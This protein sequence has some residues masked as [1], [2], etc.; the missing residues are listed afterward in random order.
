VRDNR[1]R[2][3]DIQE[4]IERVKRYSDRGRDA[5]ENDELVQVWILHHLQ[6]L[7]EAASALDSELQEMFPEIP[8]PKIIGMRNILVHEYF[9]IDLEI[10]WEVVERDLPTLERPAPGRP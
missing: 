7:G 9:G 8:W 10:V 1:E 2:L 4:S 6:N 5:F 3:L